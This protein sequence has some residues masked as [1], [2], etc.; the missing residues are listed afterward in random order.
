MRSKVGPPSRRNV[1]VVTPGTVSVSWATGA[2]GGTSRVIVLAVTLNNLFESGAV[3]V[4]R[5][6]SAIGTSMEI[7]PKDPRVNEHAPAAVICLPPG[8]VSVTP[9]PFRC[10]A[11]SPDQHVPSD[12]KYTK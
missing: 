9:P 11:F 2:S 7:V 1:T 5:L 12:L 6:T 10:T 3:P 4:A 8:Y